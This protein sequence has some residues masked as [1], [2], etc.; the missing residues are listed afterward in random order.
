MQNISAKMIP[1]FIFSS[2]FCLFFSTLRSE[3]PMIERF[4]RL[5][6]PELPPG[7]PE[8]CRKVTY[9]WTAFFAANIFTCTALALLADN[10][11]WALYTGLI[12]YL[13]LG[14]LMLFEYI[15]RR[16]R[17]PWLETLPFKQ[18]MMN[19]IKNGHTVWNSK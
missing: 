6:F 8:Y 17:Y 15:W 19:M 2:L 1:V 18:S 13:L 3:R 5:D 14:A 4:A 11:I 7:I 10:D 12:S 16:L 9:V